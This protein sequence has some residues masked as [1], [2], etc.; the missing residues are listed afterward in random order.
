MQLL[1]C[2]LAET[3][4][5]GR[6]EGRTSLTTSGQSSLQHRVHHNSL[7]HMASSKTCWEGRT[8]LAS[9]RAAIKRP[10]TVRWAEREAVLLS[11]GRTPRARAAKGRCTRACIPGA[12]AHGRVGEAM[13][14]MVAPRRALGERAMFNTQRGWCTACF[15]RPAQPIA[16]SVST[17]TACPQGRSM[18]DFRSQAT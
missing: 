6:W 5:L 14:T 15:L 17:L 8:V 4:V 11:V 7:N 2:L 18:Q 16:G 13:G 3:H 1:H 10:G 12:A 9:H